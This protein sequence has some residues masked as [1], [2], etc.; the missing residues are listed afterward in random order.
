MDNQ[1]MKET[2]LKIL[3]DHQIGTLATVENNK[4]YSRYMTFFNEA[5][6]LYTATNKE[7]HKVEDIEENPNVHILIGYTFDG[8]G[9]EFLEIEGKAEIHD[10]E[11]MK[12]KLWND[13]LKSWFSGPDD[14]N[15]IV[16]KITPVEIRIRNTK[17]KNVHRLD[18]SN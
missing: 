11:A 12:H 6:T 15:Y 18:F 8:I 2:V 4:P 10:E 16:L 17:D 14:P 3:E 9:D 7:T 13:H 1:K 5:Y